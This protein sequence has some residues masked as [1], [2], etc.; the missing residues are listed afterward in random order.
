MVTF[1][2]SDVRAKP[3]SYRQPSS[4]CTS[5][6]EPR[7]SHLWIWTWEWFKDEK[8][9]KQKKK[10]NKKKAPSPTI[11]RPQLPLHSLPSETL[12]TTWWESCF[13]ASL[14]ALLLSPWLLLPLWLSTVAQSRWGR[15]E[16]GER[17]SSDAVLGLAKGAGLG[18]SHMQTLYRVQG[19]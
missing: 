16:G 13:Q 12:H 3:L 18:G 5:S 19:G 14:P 8:K 10:R 4:Q 6:T 2:F 1:F 9:K 11:S 7:P 17:R 15:M